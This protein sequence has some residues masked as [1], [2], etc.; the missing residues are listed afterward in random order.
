MYFLC[1][2]VILKDNC[3]RDCARMCPTGAMFLDRY[4][5]PMPLHRPWTPILHATDKF[6]QDQVR[7]NIFNLRL[8]VGVTVV[9]IVT[10]LLSLIV[11]GVL[12]S[13]SFLYKFGGSLR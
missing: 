6:A 8:S 3:S 2:I 13:S 4:V 11:T 5:P 12:A 10:V 7:N 9:G 1:F